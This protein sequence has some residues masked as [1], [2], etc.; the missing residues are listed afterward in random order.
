M[1]TDRLAPIYA[2]PGPFAS[3]YLEVSRD[4]EQGDRI[5]E[6]GVRAVAEELA[7]QGAPPEVVSDV[8]ERLLRSTGSASTD[9][10]LCGRHGARRAVRR[11]DS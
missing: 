6:L 2:E 11:A 8:Q 9:Q 10:P 3:A 1:K 5:V 4:Q 7:E